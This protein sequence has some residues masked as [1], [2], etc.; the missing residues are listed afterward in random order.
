MIKLQGKSDNK[1]AIATWKRLLKS[2][3]DLSPDRRA[4][5]MKVMADAM[6]MSGD[7]HGAGSNGSGNAN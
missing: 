3:P 2:N 5:V 7:Q 4:T 1:G 6:T